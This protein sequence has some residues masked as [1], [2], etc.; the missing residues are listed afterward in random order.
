MG[1]YVSKN[2]SVCV[3]LSNLTLCLSCLNLDVSKFDFV[4]F[5]EKFV[6][7]IHLILVLRSLLCL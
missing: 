3:C 4:F 6:V 7:L 2:V 5:E 1:N